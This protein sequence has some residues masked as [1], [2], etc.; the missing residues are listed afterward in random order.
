LI[1]GGGSCAGS[2]PTIRGRPTFSLR[3]AI[4]G[5]LADAW[6]RRH[7]PGV[8]LIRYAHLSTD[9]E[10]RMRGIADRLGI[11]VPEARRPAPPPSPGGGRNAGTAAPTSG[12]GC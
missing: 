3:G 2:R 10:T 1:I 6:T 5:H 7:D 4:I 11:A 8:I 12:S 9:L